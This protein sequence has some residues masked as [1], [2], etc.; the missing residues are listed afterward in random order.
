MRAN[1]IGGKPGVFFKGW[2]KLGAA[3]ELAKELE[4]RSR[5]EFVDLAC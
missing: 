5:P 3:L 1:E 4:Q 2:V